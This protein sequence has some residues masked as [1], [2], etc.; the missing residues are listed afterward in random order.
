MSLLLV[1]AVAGPS[2]AATFNLTTDTV[3]KP[4]PDGTVVTMWGF[5][6]DGGLITVPGPALVVNPADTTLTIILTNNLPV[7]VSIVIPGLTAAMSP[8]FVDTGTVPYAIGSTGSR[9]TGDVTS[10]VGSFTIETLANGTASYTWTN[11]KPGTYLYQSGANPAVQVQMG[12]YGMLKKDVAAGF[13]YT[14][15]AYDVEVSLLFSEIDPVLVTAIAHGNYI[16]I[17]ASVPTP[18]PG[19]PVTSTIDYAPKY[20][21]I[22]GETYRT[23]TLPITAG[24]A[25]QKTLIR[26]LNAGLRT[27][28]PVLLDSHMSVIAQDGHPNTYSKEQ[29]SVILPAGKTI[30]AIFAPQAPGIYP[31]FDRRLDVS[32]ATYPGGTYEIPEGG[33]ITK[34]Q[35]GGTIA[36]PVAADDS[37]SVNMNDTLIVAAPGVL[38]NDTGSGT[39]AAALVTGVANGKLTFNPNGSFTYVPNTTYIGADTFAYNVTNGAVSNNATVTINVVNNTPPVANDQAVTTNE[40]TAV[41]ITLTATD[42]E[43]NPLTYSIVSSPMN[44]TLSGTPPAVTYTPFANFNGDDSFTFNANDGSADSNVAT[45]PIT[46]TPVNDAPVAVDDYAA[47]TRNTPIIINI[48]ANDTDIDGTINPATVA[49]TT[50][51]TR[52]GT[53]QIVTNGVL[54]TP[55]RNW[56][57]TDVFR[58][59][60]QDELGST[61]NIATVRVNVVK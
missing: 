40:D 14:G 10:R 53:A 7:P 4:L 20:F 12:L 47:T 18:V 30:D 48:L 59:T 16:N 27:H 54:F 37:Y 33:M 2:L 13:A 45:V 5:G 55:K 34:L 1:M 61:S 57:G 17:P 49:I 29:Y 44:G 51:P 42:A 24:Y 9:A 41:G 56:T 52:G 39:L 58:Y 22:N 15:K 19:Q 3:D 25:G 35:V 43:S 28:V 8:T 50:P 38:A 32:D 6:L 11:V 36:A 60:V 46:V 23:A 31:V 26:F 21:L